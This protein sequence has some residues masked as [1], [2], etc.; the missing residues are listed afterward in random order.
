MRNEKRLFNYKSFIMRNQWFEHRRRIRVIL[1]MA[2]AILIHGAGKAQDAEFSQ[3][4]ANPLY[5]N[6][7]LAGSETQYRAVVNYRNQWPGLDNGFVTYNASYD[8]YI[9][10]IHGGLG[11]LFNV[12]NAGEGILT[13]TQASLIY[14]YSLKASPRLFFNMSLQA[15]FY[16][17]SLNWGR[18]RFGDQIDLL[19]GMDLP[20]DE[21]PPDNSSVMV[22]DFAAGVVFGWKSFLHGGVAIH[23]LTE[24]NLSFYSQYENRLPLK[25]TGHLGANISCEPGGM[26]F[27]PKFYI[28]P[29]ILYQQQGN[30]HQVNLGLYVTRM[31]LVLGAWYRHNLENPDAVIV[32]IGIHCNNFKIGYSYD[33]GLSDT[34][35]YSGG[36]HEISVAWQFRTIDL[37]DIYRLAAPG[38]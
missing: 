23:H 12:D 10:K 37:R 29:N 20:T 8:Q 17:R 31:P 25:I 19:H 1:A 22:P 38:F 33:I 18:L 9:S 36:A 30:F 3:F 4:Y 7:A 5:L 13:T 21:I 6:P 16:Q 24:P 11:V 2:M 28:S 34:R 32:L 27:E 15:T 35:S 14:A 26:A